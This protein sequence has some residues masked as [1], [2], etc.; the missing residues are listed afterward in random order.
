MWDDFAVISIVNKHTHVQKAVGQLCPALSYLSGI[1]G[2]L[3]M[4]KNFYH[5]Y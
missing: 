4:K 5:E 3:G 2:S 1:Q